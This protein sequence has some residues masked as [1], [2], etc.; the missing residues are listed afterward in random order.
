MF[1]F[2]LLL[3]QIYRGT[4]LQPI[5]HKK[6]EKVFKLD[7]VIMPFNVFKLFTD[8]VLGTLKNC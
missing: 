5:L 4:I 8:Q 3:Y 7:L 2:Q 6:F 1:W